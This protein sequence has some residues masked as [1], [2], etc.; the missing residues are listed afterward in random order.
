MKK[1]GMK[2]TKEASEAIAANFA[3]PI[4]LRSNFRMRKPPAIIPAPAAGS[5]I[6]P[7]RIAAK[8]GFGQKYNLFQSTFWRVNWKLVLNVFWH[9]GHKGNNDGEF[10][11]HYKRDDDENMIFDHTQV[12]DRQKSFFFYSIVI[13][14]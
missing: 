8:I 14:G 9:E 13:Y 5:K 12:K 6:P 7:H 1:A 11:A 4:V 10:T 2:R 3:Q